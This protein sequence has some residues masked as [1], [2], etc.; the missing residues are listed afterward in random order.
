MKRPEGARLFSIGKLEN[1]EISSEVYAQAVE[2]DRRNMVPL[3]V[4]VSIQA[5]A[6]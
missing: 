1:L 5:P 2:R 4:L 3:P 6:F